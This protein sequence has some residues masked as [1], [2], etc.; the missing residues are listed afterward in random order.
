[1]QGYLASIAFAD[2]MLG[3][4]L[5]ALEKSEYASNT[6]IAL[7]SDHGWQL[8]EKEHWRK[9]ALW[10]NTA[11]SVLM[12]KAPEGMP[13]LPEGSA[14]GVKCNKI[15]SLMD[16]Y[17]TLLDLCGLPE[18]NKVD[19]RSLTP[20]LKNPQI[21]WD[22]PAITTYDFNEFSIRTDRAGARMVVLEL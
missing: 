7:W 22:Y 9:F 16:I 1:M 18:S 21:E 19:G 5:D 14:K 17:P 20:L 8:G 2:A 11:K 10:E 6:I 3:N 4:L 12:M 15:T 13:G